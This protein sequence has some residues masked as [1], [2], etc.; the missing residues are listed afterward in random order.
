LAM[1]NTWNIMEVSQNFDKFRSGDKFCIGIKDWWGV[2]P[3]V[4]G[5]GFKVK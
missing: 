5:R 1:E 2:A 4:E 3:E